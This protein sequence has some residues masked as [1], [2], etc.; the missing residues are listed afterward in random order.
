[1]TIQILKVDLKDRD[2]LDPVLKRAREDLSSTLGLVRP[3]IED[4]E[5]KG[6]SA[7]REYT[8]KFDGD[9]PDSFVVE[10]EG[11]RP[12]IDSDLEAALRKAADNIKAFHQIQIPEDKE[13]LVNGNR[14]GIRHTPVES[15]S[16]YAPG[17]K[18]LY[19]S[20]ILMGVIPA[21]LA[22]VKN[23]QIVTPP[24]KGGL[25]DGL[26]AAARIAGADRIILA[27][28]AQGIAAV[29][30]G[31]ETISASEFVIGP[32]SKFVTAAKVYLSGLGVI[33]IDSPAGPSEVLVIADDSA[34]P[35]WVAADLLS[36]AEHGEDSVAILCTDSVSLASSVAAEVD[37]AL[38]ERPKRGEMKRKSIED[39]GRI[40]VFPNLEECFAFSNR[41]APEHLEIQTKNFREDL[42][43][44]RHAGSVFLGDYSP[45]AMGDYISGTNHILPTAGAARIYSSLG[46]GTFLKRVTW[47]EVSRSSLSELYPHVKVLSEFEGLDEEHGTSV[48]IRT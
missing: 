3:I 14:L 45:V 17:G 4:V 7:L 10:L 23:V 9:V 36:Q 43:K 48:K 29:S 31:T 16:V 18:A 15:V 22:G 35:V 34:N 25:P 5:K 19:P 1:M 8:R 33:G 26:I 46:V 32:G 38:A 28:G 6:D 11:L 41:F 44:I 13:I 37:K 40:F 42:K 2:V 21:R 12:K 30:Y 20:T 24:Q 47:Q 27:G 39:H